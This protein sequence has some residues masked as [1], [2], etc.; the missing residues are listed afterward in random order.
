[1]LRKLL[2]I[3][4]LMTLSLSAVAQI[5]PN[6][7]GEPPILKCVKKAPGNEI[8]IQWDAPASIGPCF[9]QYGIY[10]AKGNRDGPYV[11]I[12]SISFSASGTRTL[13]PSFGGDVFVFL[14]NEQSCNVGA[15]IALTSD[16]LDNIVPQAAPAVRYLTVENDK[17]TI[18][19]EPAA[20][21]EVS[22]YV[23]Y[24]NVNN[25][26]T[27]ID[28]VLGR[29]NTSFTDLNSDPSN[30]IAVYRLRVLEFCEADTGLLGNITPSYNSIL[31]EN[32]PEEPCNR[33]TT[34]TWN[35]Y[36]NQN[37][38]VL[39]YIVEY[40]TDGGNTYTRKDSLSESAR[41]YVFNGL[42][43]N[44]SNCIRVRAVLPG[45]LFSSS[46]LICIVG[47]G[48][49]PVEN[50]YIQKINV[51]PAS[52]QLEYIADASAPFVELVLER[53]SNGQ[54][55]NVLTTGVS[56]Q[57]PVAGGPFLIEDFSPLINRTSYWYRVT[58]KNVCNSNYS[59]APSKTIFLEGEN[60]GLDNLLTYDEL[61]VDSS[62]VISYDLLTV[63]GTDTIVVGTAGSPGELKD[64]D[65][66]GNNQ[67]AEICYVVR[68]TYSFGNN[69]L[70]PAGD[71]TSLSN[72]VCLK[73]LPQAF[74]PNAFAPEGT[75]KVFRP[76]LSFASNENYLFEVFNR[77][78]EKVFTSNKPGQGWDGNYKGSSAALDSYLYYVTFT[79]LDNNTYNRTGYV[80]LVR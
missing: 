60:N 70:R 43:V 34:L 20:N 15:P 50:H 77:F 35:G 39:G 52:I 61:I 67:F 8:T 18:F 80:I 56:V 28:T 30:T 5:V 36:N 16:T 41:S 64:E 4:F 26:N 48:I 19:W 69:P 47:A 2:T 44:K 33:A 75:N 21:P 29:L 72:Q 45:G 57:Q 17:A 76:I 51:R 55:F 66:Y 73:P 24:S 58:V 53:S 32:S 22:A 68:G 6:R 23:I 46:N 40:S 11:K 42:E 13:N 1:M 54:S 78:G 62:V 7:T 59:T 38:G 63:N 37:I 65:V 12:D 9:S 25:F 3:V 49:T 31:L 74:V 79:G 27:P 14:V 71:F 10:I